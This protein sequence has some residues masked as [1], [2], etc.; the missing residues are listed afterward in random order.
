MA[1]HKLDT[2]SELTVRVLSGRET[3]VQSL[4]ERLDRAI[5]KKAACEEAMMQV[6]DSVKQET[7]AFQLAI[8]SVYAERLQQCQEGVAMADQ[9]QSGSSPLI[10]GEKEARARV[11]NLMQ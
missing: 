6:V 8:S 4:L 7:E 5:Q 3:R 2:S 9:A 10:R 1:S 11:D